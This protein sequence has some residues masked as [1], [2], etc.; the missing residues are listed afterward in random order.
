[1][2][3]KKRIKTKKGRNR[4]ISICIFSQHIGMKLEIS[5]EIKYRKYTNKRKFTNTRMS[6]R[7][8]QNL[9]IPESGDR[10]LRMTCKP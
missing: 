3:H 9:M 1:M 4:E 2:V 6:E 8:I 10:T 7:R 5:T